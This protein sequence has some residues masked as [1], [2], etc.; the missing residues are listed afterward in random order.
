MGGQALFRYLFRSY[1]LILN[2]CGHYLTLQN[3]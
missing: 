2:S 1:L 3:A